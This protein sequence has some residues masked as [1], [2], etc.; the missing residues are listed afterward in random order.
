ML[1]RRSGRDRRHRR[2]CLAYVSEIEQALETVR[3]LRPEILNYVR[4]HGPAAAAY[5]D[6]VIDAWYG[7][8]L[9]DRI[10]FVKSCSGNKA[11]A[12]A[13]SIVHS[14]GALAAPL[15]PYVVRRYY[16]QRF[17]GGRE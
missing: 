17:P 2:Q 11:M 5:F 8:T 9:A 13:W 14:A 3:F 4:N 1:E 15:V 12:D 16:G 7:G 6:S 10:A